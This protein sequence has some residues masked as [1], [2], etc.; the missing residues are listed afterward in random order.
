MT[1]ET[2]NG[3]VS[4]AT[5]GQARVDFFFKALRDTPKEKIFEMLD[6]SWQESPL[7]TLKLIFY[8]RDC[9]GGAGEKQLFF[10][11]SE[12]L[13]K[14]HMFTFIANHKKIPYFGSWKDVVV[15]LDQNSTNLI[16]VHLLNLICDQLNE[17]IHEMNN[18]NPVS[19]CAKYAPSE[20]K[21]F[22]HLVPMISGHLVHEGRYK[23]I[24]RKQY[25]SPLRAYI[26]I[27]EKLMCSANWDE[28]EFSK[29]PSRA[30]FKLQ[31]AFERHTPEKFTEW[32]KQV[33]EGKAKV[34][35][36]QLDPPELIQK[37]INNNFTETDEILWESMVKDAAKLGTLSN[38]LVVCDVSGSMMS[39]CNT[40][41]PISVSIAFG[42][43]ISEL[44]MGRFHNK[45]VTFSEKPSL[46]EINGNTLRERIN[47]LEKA[48]WGM[49]TNFQAVFDLILSEAKMWNLTQD[50]LPS[51]I[52]CISDMQFNE[53]GGR[54]TNL[55]LV[56][57]K[58][59]KAG[60]KRPE[61]I[62]WNVAGNTNDFPSS[63][64]NKGVGLV[65]GY[66]KSILKTVMMGKIPDAYSMMRYT[67][68]VERY[69]CLQLNEIQ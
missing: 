27:V 51:R 20:H 49:S 3:A 34:N 57:E 1:A 43:L 2:W 31:K 42:L 14:N 61:L 21:H 67:I 52:I 38:C 28:I 23:E 55:E 50:Q 6:A 29:V 13:I 37:F 59:E 62:F 47:N 33:S 44:T 26:N 30:M 45:V 68:D 54:Q 17:D 64:S 8:K 48:P 7:D 40:V 10:Y 35:S 58:F 39:S 46:Y 60:F 63:S 4:L 15:L 32:K 12:W 56:D 22:K 18:G 5:T 19:L 16:G 11:C 66:N 69:D 65:S 53:C 9:R 24:Y 41:K 36:G 25:L